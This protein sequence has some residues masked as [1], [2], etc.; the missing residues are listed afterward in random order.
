[1]PDSLGPSHSTPPQGGVKR[2][3]PTDRL[4]RTTQVTD[5]TNAE[6][7][8]YLTL[9]KLPCE[10]CPFASHRWRQR[11]Q[12]VRQ[13]LDE[14]EPVIIRIAIWTTTAY[15]CWHIIMQH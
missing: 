13:F 3:K 10:H 11:L 9:G 4:A 14:S 7:S 15:F 12:Q 5:L 6:R 8:L 1:M 2:P